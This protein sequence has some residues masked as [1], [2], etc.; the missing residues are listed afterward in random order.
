MC[1]FHRNT[2]DIVYC[3][4]PGGS[5]MKTMNLRIWRIHIMVFSV[6]NRVSSSG[7][8]MTNVLLN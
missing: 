8:I 5:I 7:Q 3:S 2:L 1:A 6:E 4:F